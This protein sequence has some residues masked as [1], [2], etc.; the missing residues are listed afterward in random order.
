METV[1][2]IKNGYFAYTSQSIASVFMKKKNNLNV[3]K[4][5]NFEIKQ[6][7]KIGVIGKNGS[8]KTTLLKILSNRYT[9]DSGIFKSK[10][11][12]FHLDTESFGFNNEISGDENVRNILNLA[13][14]NDKIKLQNSYIFIKKLSELSNY[15][16]SPLKT[17]SSGMRARILFCTAIAILKTKLH[18]NKNCGI[19]V[20]ELL[21]AGD[22]FF[23]SK[24]QHTLNEILNNPRLTLIIVSHSSSDI[25]R[26]CD[27]AIYLEKGK[28]KKKG[29]ALSIIKK[30]EDDLYKEMKTFK[31]NVRENKT[32]HGIFSS[33]FFI[34]SSKVLQNHSGLKFTSI[35]LQGINNKK[36]NKLKCKDGFKIYFELKNTLKKSLPFRISLTFFSPNGDW[37]YNYQS[38]MSLFDITKKS[39]LRKE[40]IFQHNY[41]NKGPVLLTIGLHKTKKKIRLNDHYQLFNRSFVLNI[42][43]GNNN[44]LFDK[45]PVKFQ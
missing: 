19:L 6:G 44:A 40:I 22:I 21:S 16:K 38:P 20:D 13:F 9:L 37:L 24:I 36:I 41:F 5:L 4:N 18:E 28:I 12:F 25:I 14:N 1:L 23:K 30:Y 34:K 10:I 29:Q 39:I 15:F 11:E 8:G 26:F 2:E 35:F 42:I 17:Y 43:E 33:N 32:D 45:I 3:I 7:D 27:K 31:S